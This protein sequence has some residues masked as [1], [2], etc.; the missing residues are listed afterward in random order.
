MFHGCD[1]SL[2]LYSPIR[3]SYTTRAVLI[4]DLLMYRAVDPLFSS[5][6]GNRKICRASHSILLRNN[7]EV[8]IQ[9]CFSFNEFNRFLSNNDIKVPSQV[10][11]YSSKTRLNN[12]LQNATK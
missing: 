7:L 3:S 9:E 6:F 4:V 1:S 11:Y 10:T 12:L 8:N 5:V 2:F